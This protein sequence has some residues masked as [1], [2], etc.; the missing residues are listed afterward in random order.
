M[1]ESANSLELISNLNKVI[2][3]R[4]LN[5][6]IEILKKSQQ[7]EKGLQEQIIKVIKNVICDKFNI[8]EK[9]LL[10]GNSRKHNRRW[11]LSF[12]CYFVYISLNY[13]Q[14]EISK[15]ISRTN[16]CVSKYIKDVLTLSESIKYEKELLDKKEKIEI[17]LKEKITHIL[18]Y[19]E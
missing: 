4:G 9:K 6:T 17:L 16:A 18:R 1:S 7:P 13:T 8:T 12:Y 2:E 15:I 14:K 3:K 10:F 11:A 19:G 5:K